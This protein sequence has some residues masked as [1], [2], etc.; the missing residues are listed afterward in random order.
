MGRASRDPEAKNLSATEPT[1]ANRL[2]RFNVNFCIEERRK[3]SYFYCSYLGLREF[4]R[5]RL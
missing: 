1:A 4:K 3:I 2:C 5:V